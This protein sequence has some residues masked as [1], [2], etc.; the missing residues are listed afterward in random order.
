VQ[1]RIQAF[2]RAA[3]VAAHRA[4]ALPTH[5]AAAL[6]LSLA[7]L[8]NRYELDVNRV[9]RSLALVDAADT[10][11]ALQKAVASACAS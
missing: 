2:G 9:S 5:D 1:A 8:V 4:R 6:Q 10:D 7:A 11:P 3:D